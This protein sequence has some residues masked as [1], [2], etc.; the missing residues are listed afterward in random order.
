MGKFEKFVVLAVLFLV[1]LILVV[2]LNTDEQETLAQASLGGAEE[3]TPDPVIEPTL[4]LVPLWKVE[5]V[6]EGV[7]EFVAEEEAFDPST[8]LLS[9]QVEEEPMIESEFLLP[10]DLIKLPEGAIIQELAGL[11]ETYDSNFFSITVAE[12]ETYQS[13]ALKYYGD[14]GYAG[15]IR[16]ANDDPMTAPSGETVMLP[17]FD[18]R[19]HRKDRAS[20]KTHPVVT[21]DTFGGIAQRFYGDARQWKKIMDAN[22]DKVS[23]ETGLR[24]GM[25]L[26][27]P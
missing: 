22:L 5:D 14:D 12:D 6:D 2:S 24:A 20:G 23:S 3:V 21:G 1:T 17:A 27:I 16:Q 8:V 11:T 18:M 26:V 25:I 13:I 10:E 19:V 7:T 4:D 9:G 15:M